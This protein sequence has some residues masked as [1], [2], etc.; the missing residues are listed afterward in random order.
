[1]SR[2]LIALSILGT[3]ALLIWWGRGEER[4]RS[5][6]VASPEAPAEWEETALAAPEPAPA[7]ASPAGEAPALPPDPAERGECAMLVRV[8]DAET[9]QPIAST[10]DLWR[11]DAPGNEEWTAGD[12]LQ[13]TAEVPAEGARLEALPAG[14]YRPICLAERFS[15]EDPPPVRV[16]GPLTEVTFRILMPRKLHACVKVVDVRGAPLPK[17]SVRQGSRTW[18]NRWRDPAWRKP[19]ALR[20]A[21]RNVYLQLGGGGGGA[22][23]RAKGIPQPPG[24]FRLG[25]FA[26]DSKQSEVR[27]HVTVAVE[28][29]NDVRVAVPG[30]ATDGLTFLGLA[31]PFATVGGEL[32][33]QDGRTVAEAGGKVW[34]SFKAVALDASASAPLLSDLPFHIDVT[35]PGYKPVAFEHCLG[36]PLP[37]LVFERAVES[38]K[39]GGKEDDS[40]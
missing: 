32:R 11:L 6:H 26:E 36:E 35:V 15:A 2:A 37:S 22:Y 39:Q 20:G 10:V 33:M 4:A 19:R 25:P 34:A 7:E 31:V 16:E 17:G 30:A 40:D 9:Q 8:L 28:G 13:L 21:K 38:P 29:C 5:G 14:F 23:V 3:A 27:Y 12:Q 24:G 18:H 1:M